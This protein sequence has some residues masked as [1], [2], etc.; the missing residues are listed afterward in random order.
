M[1][2]RIRIIRLF[3]SDLLVGNV[4]ETL[5]GTKSFLREPELQQKQHSDSY[6]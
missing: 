2:I 1:Q 5:S 6:Q 3:R 4:I